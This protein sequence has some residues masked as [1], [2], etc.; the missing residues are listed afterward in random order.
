MCEHISLS[1]EEE[2]EEDTGVFVSIDPRMSSV[3]PLEIMRLR[4]GPRLRG[5]GPRF[6][7]GGPMLTEKETR[8]YRKGTKICRREN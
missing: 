3:S 1:G 5:E 6:I 2:T 8:I 4:E 7:E